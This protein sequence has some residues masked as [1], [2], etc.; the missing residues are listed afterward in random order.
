MF[1]YSMHANTIKF[2]AVICLSLA[3]LIALIAFVPTY[4]Q[5]EDSAQ[6]GADASYNYE[7]IK[8]NEDRINFFKQFGWEVNPQPL[9]EEEVVIPK[10][11]DKIFSQY[12]EI[13]RAQG[14]DLTAFKKKCVKRYTYA[15]T[16]YPGY[17]GEVYINILVYRNNVI[18]GDVCSADVNG[19]VHGLERK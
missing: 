8:T 11:F 4:M 3:A 19:F 10:D 14:L 17:D 16:N 18:A 12:N 6:V 15:V 1:I 13:Q 7:K 5:S 9:R 2:F